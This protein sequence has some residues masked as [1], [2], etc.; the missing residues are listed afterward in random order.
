MNTKYGT[1]SYEG[2]RTTYLRHLA[3]TYCFN[4]MKP[5]QQSKIQHY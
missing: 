5:T 3:K 2:C 4:K 1:T